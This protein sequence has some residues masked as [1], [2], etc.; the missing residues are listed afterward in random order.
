MKK[1]IEIV[2]YVHEDNQYIAVTLKGEYLGAYNMSEC[3][4]IYV[5]KEIATFTDLFITDIFNEISDALNPVP[6]EIVAEAVEICI[7][8]AEDKL[9]H[10]EE[11]TEEEY[12]VVK[13]ILVEQGYKYLI[14]TDRGLTPLVDVDV[15]LLV[16]EQLNE[17]EE[18]Y[19]IEN[20][21]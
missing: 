14:R 19:Q 10:N 13:H 3:E 9:L 2:P 7:E 18:K 16:C 11:I 8:R 15:L 6:K 21:F 12:L 17:N 1:E 20:I 4:K 5:A